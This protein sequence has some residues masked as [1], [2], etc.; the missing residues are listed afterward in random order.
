MET[1]TFQHFRYEVV[2]G[3]PVELPKPKINYYQHN[4]YS[5][6]Q[7]LHT[8]AKLH[9]G[10]LGKRESK[11]VFG[12]DAPPDAR[13]TS[14]PDITQLFDYAERMGILEP[15]APADVTVENLPG[16]FTPYKLS[17]TYWEKF[18][19]FAG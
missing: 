6:Q 7:Y 19:K 14:R 12:P 16:D 4:Q 9:V 17:V 15:A 13:L 18:D 3:E 1:E 8:L 10:S 2:L 5:V 11:W